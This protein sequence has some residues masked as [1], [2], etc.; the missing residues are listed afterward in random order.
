MSSTTVID[1][2]QQRRKRQVPTN[3]TGSNLY[4]SIIGVE[5]NNTFSLNT[6]YGDT[7][8]AVPTAGSKYI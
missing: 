2:S 8:D 3:V 6:T 7:T 5:N 1:D 4:L